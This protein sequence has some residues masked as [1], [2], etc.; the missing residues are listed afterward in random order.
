MK[1]KLP[2]AIQGSLDDLRRGTMPEPRP[3]VAK[4]AEPK[5]PVKPSAAGR[6]PARKRRPESEPA[7]DEAAARDGVTSDATADP[8][9]V[10]ASGEAAEPDAV[11][12]PDASVVADGVAAGNETTAAGAGAVP[13]APAEPDVIAPPDPE[14]ALAGAA[15]SDEVR[16]AP[17]ARPKPGLDRRHKA[18]G[19]VDSAVAHAAF[20]GLIPIPFL[21][22][23]GVTAV[24]VDMAGQLARLYGVPAERDR[25]RAVAMGLVSGAAPMLF[26]SLTA[27]V[28]LRVVPGANIVGAAV[29]SISAAKCAR[30][31]GMVLIGHF[32]SG[33]T[34]LDLDA[35]KHR[36]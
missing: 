8:G 29:T 35:G 30:H 7:A 4:T 22:V 16:P 13:A 3:E 17:E 12:S 36:R 14:P 15:A 2:S 9:V 32:E 19:I 6:R 27:M 11:S 23:A 31:V 21:D 33:G 1:R 24:V 5:Q 26:G 10:P 25:L 28:L 18:L 20:G 34:L